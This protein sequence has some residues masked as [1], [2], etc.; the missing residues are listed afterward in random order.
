MPVMLT[1]CRKRYYYTDM[2][3]M[4][5]MSPDELQAALGKQLQELRI[6][7]NLDQITTAEKAGISEKALRNLEAGRGSSIETLV[8][9]LKALDSLDGL[10]LLAPKPSVSPLALLRNSET[11]RRRVR[12][13][14]S[15][16]NQ[17]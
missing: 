3:D 1:F 17:G 12:R 6:A 14:R 16:A 8:R 13:S 15:E 4:S 5:F 11:A 7:K 2:A 10:R 9:V